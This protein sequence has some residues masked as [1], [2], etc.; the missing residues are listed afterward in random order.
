MR[1]SRAMR[2][3]W[4]GGCEELGVERKETDDSLLVVIGTAVLESFFG[5]REVTTETLLC[6]E[7]LRNLVLGLD[8]T[9][10]FKRLRFL[11]ARE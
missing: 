8:S 6:S 10:V 7:P 9:T 2:C 5:R 4:Q 1:A 11:N 3:P